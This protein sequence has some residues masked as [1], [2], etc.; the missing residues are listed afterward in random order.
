MKTI[1]QLLVLAGVTVASATTKP[2]IVLIFA[3]DLGYGDLSCYGAEKVQTPHID[4]LAAEGRKYTDGHSAAAVCT[5]SRYAM[6]TG[7]YPF[8]IGN[9]RP[10]FASSPL[11]IDTKKVTL[12]S[13]LQDAG[14][15]TSCIGK[16]HLGFGEKKPDWNGELKPG[17]LELGFD[18]Y[19]GVPVVNSH[20]PFVYV[21]NHQVVGL[22]PED[23]IE[24]GKKAN[25]KEYPEKMH[26]GSMGGGDAAHALYIDD[27][28]GTHLTKKA[29]EWIVE[30]KEQPFFLKLST[31]NIHHPFTP[32]PQ[33][34]GTSQCGLYGD[35]IHELDWMVGELSLIHI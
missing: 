20:P 3:D 4:Q 7:E 18:Y 10:V 31:T 25:T 23:P 13:V 9:S 22:V 27:Q 21:E 12:S 6:M 5:P 8:R 28:V 2:N 17:P 14:Y 32:H 30:N 29:T 1:T 24:Y 26:L 11:I 35:Y 19:Y 33:F 16:W 34:V 15:A